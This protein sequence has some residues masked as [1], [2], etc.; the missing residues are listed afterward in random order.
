MVAT[1]GAWFS[2]GAKVHRELNHA[3][4]VPTTKHP[5]VPVQLGPKSEAGPGADLPLLGPGAVDGATQLIREA[6]KV[7]EELVRPAGATRVNEKD[8]P[9][10][11]WIPP[12]AFQMGCSVGD[13]A[14]ND[15]D[16]PASAALEA[17]LRSVKYPFARSCSSLGPDQFRCIRRESPAEPEL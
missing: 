14:C 17:S 11:V 16:K 12:G 1:A 4:V 5:A 3:P 2:S 9:K 6:Q 8:G 10:Y 15:L 7:P 13:L